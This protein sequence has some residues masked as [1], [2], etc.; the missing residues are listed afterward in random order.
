MGNK[1]NKNYGI[2]YALTVEN[3]AKIM[4]HCLKVG[5]EI[6]EKL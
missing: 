1:I 4:S 5:K 6:P 3:S 2:K